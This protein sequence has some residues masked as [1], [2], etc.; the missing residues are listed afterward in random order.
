MT[1]KV[2]AYYLHGHGRTPVVVRTVEEMDRLVDDLLAQPF[3]NSVSTMYSS[4]R[5]NRPNGLPDHELAVAVSAED[6]VGGLWFNGD[7]ANWYTRGTPSRYDQVFYYYMGSEREFPHDSEIPL[8]LVRQAAREFLLN[9][10]QRPTC[11]AWQKFLPFDN[12]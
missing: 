10:G 11:V 4:A 3:D 8:D 2:T 6:G 7:G 5:P 1:A 12:G 9:G